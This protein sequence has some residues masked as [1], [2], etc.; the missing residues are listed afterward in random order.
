M[1]RI[2]IITGAIFGVLLL[3]LIALPFLIPSSV[4]KT[5]IENAATSALGREVTLVGDPSLSIF[6]S[7][8]ARIDGV[9]VA[10][11]EGFTD[12]L[13]IEAGSLKANVRL[14]P[15]FSQRVEINEFT[16]EDAT[17]RLE[18]LADGRANWE[19]GSDEED[20]TQTETPESEGGFAAGIDRARL[21]NTA[22]YYTD[23]TTDTQ[24]ALT[25]FNASASV[26][27]LDRPLTSSG[28][29]KVNGQAF[30]Y[31]IRLETLAALSEA[32]PVTLK[33][34]LGTDYGNVSYDGAVTLGDTPELEGRFDVSSD[35]I[36]QVLTVLGGGDLPINT[37]ELKSI[38]ANGSI[39]GPASTAKL[40][41]SDF[42]VKATGLDLT[43]AGDLTLGE[44]PIL[45]GDVTLDAKNAERLLLVRPQHLPSLALC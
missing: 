8:S 38:R 17:V 20:T 1:K 36:G 25:D 3:A 43:Y 15:L 37:G 13:M 41:F 19:F 10:N 44:A 22:V 40:A 35:T 12:P 16:L 24:Y 33:A 23:R 5:Q 14:W 30:E 18:R 29:G 34:S 42:T 32:L 31:D 6:P 26:K 27:A 21:S 2:L 9:T 4:Y 39:S 11:S 28:D 45:N 7:I